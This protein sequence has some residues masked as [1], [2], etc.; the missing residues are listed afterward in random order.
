ME[1]NTSNKID[2]LNQ[3]IESTNLL[4][5]VVNAFDYVYLNIK[6]A[7]YFNVL[8]YSKEKYLSDVADPVYDGLRDK[9]FLNKINTDVKSV[10][11]TKLKLTQWRNKQMAKKKTAKKKVAKKKTA[12]KKSKK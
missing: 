4:D 2:N 5:S 10:S 12:K 11:N 3:M 9:G 8:G 7:W 6:Y 1:N